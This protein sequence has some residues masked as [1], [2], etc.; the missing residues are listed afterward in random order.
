MLFIN[1]RNLKS[2]P[3]NFKFITMFNLEMESI[4]TFEFNPLL[5]DKTSQQLISFTFSKSKCADSCY[6]VFNICSQPTVTYTY[7]R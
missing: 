1:N 2:D 6:I 5:Y 7:I 4:L 3:L